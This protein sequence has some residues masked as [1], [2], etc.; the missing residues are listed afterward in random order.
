MSMLCS[1]GAGSLH[2]SSG[3]SLGLDHAKV[4][5]LQGNVV[6]DCILLDPLHT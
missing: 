1:T 4:G 6:G 2:V 5:L 3:A